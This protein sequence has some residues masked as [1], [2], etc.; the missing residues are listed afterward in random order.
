MA[1]DNAVNKIVGNAVDNTAPV[2]GLV[3]TPGSEGGKPGVIEYK[4]L[5]LPM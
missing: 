3:P 4:L 2:I 1:V 5:Y